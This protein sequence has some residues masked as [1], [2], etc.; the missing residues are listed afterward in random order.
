MCPLDPRIIAS[1]VSPA[2]G[3]FD[4]FQAASRIAQFQAAQQA[5][6]VNQL[7]LDA[8]QRA[9]FERKNLGSAIRGTM[10]TDPVTGQQR[11]NIPGALGRAYGTSQDPLG[12]LKIETE[13]SKIQSETNKADL[14]ARK[15]KLEQAQE[16]FKVG[17]QVAQGIE[18]RIAAG[19]DPQMAW[20]WGLKTME[21]AGLDT[22]QIPPTFDANSL[23]GWRS[24]A[25]TVKEKLDAE[26]AA[27]TAEL[28]KLELD[29]TRKRTE[30]E[31]RRV[32]LAETAEQRQQRGEGLEERKVKVAEAAEQ[33]Q[34]GEPLAKPGQALQD[35]LLAR[36]GPRSKAKGYTTEET[37][38]AQEAV[39]NAAIQ[40]AR[41]TGTSQIVQ[42]PE[43]YAR[44]NPRSG[45]VEMI[46]GPSGRLQP[47]PT[48]EESRAASF[49]DGIQQAHERAT[50][51][52]NKG[53][54]P[55]PLTQ[56][57]QK[58][59]FGNYL[60]PAEQQQYHQAILQFA[61]NLLRKESGAAISQ[62]EYD[63]TNK[64]YFP[65]PGDGPEVIKQK[66]QARQGVLERVQREGARAAPTGAAAAGGTRPHAGIPVEQMTP[67]QLDDVEAWARKQKGAP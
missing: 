34:A 49:A 23:A 61:Q 10:T 29:E 42:T 44:V 27:V 14:E 26:Q 17:G 2:R 28:R 12:L 65:Q 40:K 46:E 62:S 24:T 36:Y 32:G 1:A 60:L 57:A 11:P 63:M 35:E 20:Q 54:G 43:G 51:L 5:Q 22:R 59:P 41:E 50:A 67:Q 38:R 48:T 30:L 9:E 37:A 13:Y 55:T 47:K 6:Q 52:E 15:A 66:Q 4:P 31:R 45:A 3:P 19:E 58:V 8:A 56:A 18:A 7:Q 53:V 64:T 39:V 16:G 33:R 25:T 21:R